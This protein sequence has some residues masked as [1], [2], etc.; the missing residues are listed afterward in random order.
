MRTYRN[1]YET[2]SYQLRGKY[3]SF[4]DRLFGRGY[5]EKNTA[6]E[7]VIQTVTELLTDA[8]E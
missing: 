1:Y 6:P 7:L 2:D 3:G 8:A 5:R 4:V